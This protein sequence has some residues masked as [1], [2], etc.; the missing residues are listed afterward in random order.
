MRTRPVRGGRAGFLDGVGK[1][2]R[3]RIETCS[4]NYVGCIVT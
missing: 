4:K 3:G 1:G 2:P